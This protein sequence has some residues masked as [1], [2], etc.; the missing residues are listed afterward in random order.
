MAKV[1][2]RIVLE[3]IGEEGFRD[4]RTYANTPLQT[5]VL[6]QDKLNKADAEIAEQ[7]QSLGMV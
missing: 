3:V 2:C 1:T 6:L 4:E 5:V 7:K